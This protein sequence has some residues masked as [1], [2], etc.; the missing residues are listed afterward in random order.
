M[1]ITKTRFVL[2]RH[3]DTAPA[4]TNWDRLLTDKGRTQGRRL[5]ELLGG[6]SFLS[7]VALVLHS[8]T[9]RTTEMAHIIAD[10]TG[11]P[12]GGG[13]RPSLL[14]IPKLYNSEGDDGRILMAMYNRLGTK[15]SLRV[16]LEQDY[17]GAMNR[18]AVAGAQ[19]VLSAVEA[20]TPPPERRVVP[21]VA[22][23]IGLQAIAMG[24]KKSFSIDDDVLRDIIIGEGEALWLEPDGSITFVRQPAN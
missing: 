13:Y 5:Q 14:S 16:F 4:P 15:T 8:P 20:A 9:P 11:L 18:F 24:L 19:A 17:T 2:I 21:I 12:S 10:Q 6:E 1:G 23:A 3:G 22:H 7:S